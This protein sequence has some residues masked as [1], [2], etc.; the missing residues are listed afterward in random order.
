MKHMIQLGPTMKLLTKLKV[1]QDGPGGRMW[2]PWD[3]E[4][5]G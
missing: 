3:V 1:M 2:I 4:G 5:T